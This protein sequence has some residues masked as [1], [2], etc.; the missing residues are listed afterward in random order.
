MQTNRKLPTGIRIRHARGCKGGSACKCDSFEA[1][2][3]DARASRKA[4]FTVK[5][6]KRK[7][8]I[9]L[10]R[11][12]FSGPGAL[13]A[14]KNWRRDAAPQVARGEVTAQPRRRLE[15]A[16][17][18]WLAK[19]EAGEILSKRRT[20]FAPGTIRDYRADLERYVFPTLGHRPF[21]DVTADDLQQIIDR[22][23]GDGLAGQT[24]RNVVVAVQSF[25]RRQRGVIDPTINLELPQPGGKRERAA[26]VQEAETLLAVLGDDVRDIYATA[27]YAGLRRGELQAL[28]VQDVDFDAGTISIER[29][30]DQ[31]DGPKD[32]KS[33]AGRR[34]VP[35]PDTLRPFLAS[36][37]EGKPG[38][39]VFGRTAD[40]PFVPNSVRRHAEKAWVVAAVG[41]F[42]T[43]TAPAVELVPIELHACRHSYATWLD[44]AGVSEIRAARYLGHSLGSVTAGYTH[45][46][47][48]QLAED[49]RRI[50]EYLSGAASGKV[51]ALAQAG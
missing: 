34:Q 45:R 51:V 25:Y 13:A 11:K 28:R 43:R 37:L 15:D 35:I 6:G 2:V 4:G 1:S 16:A 31:V 33:R 38:D 23:N 32:P 27:F 19:C 8:K 17:N 30:W 48:A 36:H 40:Q 49:G 44:H 14:A 22:M 24:V 39:L 10:I 47:E 50:E 18:E 5:D 7:Q 21:A 26:T 12:T 29:S 20:A 42:L 41:A 3:Y 9:I 46:L